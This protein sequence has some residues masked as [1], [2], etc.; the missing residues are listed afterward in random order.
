M[1]LVPTDTFLMWM[2]GLIMAM[3][4]IGLLFGYIDNGRGDG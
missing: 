3:V 4:I 2:G 1:N